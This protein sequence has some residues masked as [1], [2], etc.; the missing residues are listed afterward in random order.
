MKMSRAIGITV[1]VIVLLGVPIVYLVNT[2]GKEVESM[3]KE[4]VIPPIDTSRPA[5]TETATFALG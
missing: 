5:E 1:G 2:S 4:V 3:N